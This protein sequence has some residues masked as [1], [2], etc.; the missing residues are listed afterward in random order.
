MMITKAMAEELIKY[1]YP[2]TKAMTEYNNKLAGLL[3]ARRAA[4]GELPDADES[5]FVEELDHIWW[6][7][8]TPEE[9]SAL[10]ENDAGIDDV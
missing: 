7:V 3:S 10:E 9:R 6:N 1:K 4:G 2:V 8:L 5:K